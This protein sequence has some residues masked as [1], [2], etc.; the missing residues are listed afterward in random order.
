MSRFCFKQQGMFSVMQR[1]GPV[2]FPAACSGPSR[3][4]LRLL[5]H[6]HPTFAFTRGSYSTHS[7]VQV[8]KCSFGRVL[9]IHPRFL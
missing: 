9:Y 2:I 8:L 3:E 1:N 4:H 6:L 5:S 7:D